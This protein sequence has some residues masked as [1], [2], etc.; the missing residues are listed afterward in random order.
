MI[1]KTTVSELQI[2]RSSATVTRRGEAE[3]Q[4][5]RNVIYV[6]GMTPTSKRDG[7][8]LKFP[9]GIRA[10]NIQVIDLEDAELGD[11]L[12]SEGIKK[13]IEELDYRIATCNM[14]MELRKANGDFSNRSEISVDA[15]ERYMEELP[16]K[17]IELHKELTELN[18]EKEELK[19]KL[20]D[21]VADE[22]NPL[23][24]A[25]LFSEKEGMVPFVLQYQEQAASWAPLYEI[26]FVSDSEPL[27][28]SMKARIMQDTKEDWKQ[29]KV[30]LYTG[31]PAISQDI[32]E[33]LSEQLSLNVVVK[34]KAAGRAMGYAD[35]CACDEE[36]E[37]CEAPMLMSMKMNV[38]E[39]DE[40]DTMTA[41]I[42]PDLKDIFNETD[43]N[44]ALLQTFKVQAD[45]RVLSIPKI[46][47]KCYLTASIASVE[48][49]LP[50]A[51]AA[52]YL[53]ET[54]AGNVYVD[55]RSEIDR[56][57]LSLGQDERVTVVRTELPRKTQDVFL[58]NQK[59]ETNT[60]NIRLI[61]NSSGIVRIS[62]KDQIP[63]STEKAISVEPLEL[64]GGVVNEDTGE[65]VWDIIAESGK[66]FEIVLS[67]NIAW[68][69]DRI[70]TR[71]KVRRR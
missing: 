15:Q 62:V 13:S 52:V 67:Y 41:F 39:V 26:R 25:E 6:S 28:V 31:N 32:P 35:G 3:L 70:M 20:D 49:P 48:W 60:S 12:E 58:K 38:A 14:M 57:T 40:A 19:K 23:I 7:F 5:G 54:F 36:V 69:K 24:M 30:T 51:N 46:T 17:L 63:V 29:V 34:G 33:L 66:A 64:S 68:P 42:L 59:K 37:E 61:N 65:I 4:S 8:R 10:V 2:Y 55:A 47:D 50:P 56:F 1:I 18:R 9:E 53:N 16:G 21:A 22:E 27:D 45:Y 43:G 71:T 11:G 44:I